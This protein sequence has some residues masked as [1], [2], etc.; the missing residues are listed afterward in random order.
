MLYKIFS[1][2]R[3]FRALLAFDRDLARKT[4]AAGCRHCLDGPLHVANYRRK[5]RGGNFEPDDELCQRLS[6]CCGKEGCRHRNTPPSVRFLGRRVYFA[7]IFLLVSAMRHGVTPPR[8]TQIK[9][10]IP[11]DRRT[12]ERWRQWW[13]ETFVQTPFWKMTRARFASPLDMGAMPMSLLVAFGFESMRAYHEP[14]LKALA[15]L[16][17]SSASAMVAGLRA[18]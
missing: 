3:F 7:A 1:D 11:V 10:L 6:F 2:S 16:G 13:Q 5:P 12:L 15:F 8:A 18:P 9:R 17:P 14:L 4:Q